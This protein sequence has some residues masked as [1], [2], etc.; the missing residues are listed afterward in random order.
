MMRRL[1][2]RMK[3]LL[4][5]S[6]RERE[7]HEEIESHFVL[8]VDENLRAGMT[9]DEAIRSARM[10][11]GNVDDI[12]ESCR[13]ASG[14]PLL[15]GIFQDFRYAIRGM[16]R[17]PAFT[18]V[19]VAILALGIGI[20]VIVFTVTN[21]VLFEGFP[22]VKDND[23]VVYLS[24]GRGCC[25]SYPDF[26]DWRAQAKSFEGMVPI[27]GIQQSFSDNSG[28]PESFQVSEV[29]VGAFQLAGQQ[30]IAGRDFLPTDE[31]PGAPRVAILRYSFWERRYGKDPT[32]IGREVRVNGETATIVGVMPNGF[33]FPQNSDLWVPLIPTP[34]ARDRG[35]RGLWFVFAR[36]RPGVTVESSRAEMETIGRRLGD[37]YPLTNQG[38]NLIPQV[39]QFHEFFIGDN[40]TRIYQAMLV[41]VVFVLLIACANLA[42]L[43][44][45]RATDRSRE[46]W[47]RIALGAG[48]WRIVRQLFVESL[49]LSALGGFFGWWIAKLGVRLFALRASGPSLSDSIGGDWFNNTVD[50]TMDYRIFVY[51]VVVSMVTGVLFALV[52]AFRLSKLD[53]NVSLKEGARGSTDSRTAR[54][55]STLLV[56]A[57]MALALVLITGAG[58]M[59]RSFLNIYN[60]R[61]GFKPGNIATALFALPNARYATPEA[62]YSFYSRLKSKLEAVPGVDAVAIASQ[63]PTASLFGEPYE[64]DNTV[65]GSVDAQSRP[66]VSRSVVG[67]AYFSA[68]GVALLS[69]REFSEIDRIESEPVA[70][71]N[72]H[73]ASAAWPNQDAVGKRLRFLSTNG[74]GE[75]WRTVVGVVPN[76]AFRDRTRQ[77]TAPM[78]YLPYLQQPRS[79]MWLVVRTR[80]TAGS[81]SNVI[82]Q[83]VQYIDPDLPPKLGPFSLADFLADSYL[84]RATTGAMFL[85]FAAI[86]LLL[87]SVGLYAVI[88]HFVGRRTA[89]IGIR[90]ALGGTERDIRMMVLRHGLTPICMGLVIGVAGSVAV[91]Q[92]LKAQLVGVSPIDPLSF[93]IAAAALT[94]GG[95]LGCLIP[96]RRASRIDPVTALRKDS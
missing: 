23:R 11:F 8:H 93:I 48:R 50:F 49:S 61:L 47:M 87:A 57:E 15:E 10:K 67:A 90:M 25:A 76:L 64:L 58:V 41:A 72:H 40:A 45:A 60:A 33:S 35:E 59:V 63:P 84:Y 1:V 54:R 68:L 29:G 74:A 13:E 7:M 70:I 94:L 19:A 69:G 26:E 14:F 88:A 53:I 28:F 65:S 55:L 27:H 39:Q 85:V 12:M 71:V 80:A 62:Q 5:R 38:R 43:L 4:H 66:V 78:V 20:N 95:T 81:L 6:R 36:L 56:A 18:A 96:A 32:I 31:L 79:E 91:G 42:N 21:A 22:L 9:R 89:E 16:R 3:A 82:R 37:A 34:Q 17:S 2:A 77:Q 83:E 44:L 73:F 30:P 51:M 86:A 24:S 52:P 75:V 92:L 46:A